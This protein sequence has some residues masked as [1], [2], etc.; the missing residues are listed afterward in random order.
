MVLEHILLPLKGPSSRTLGAFRNVFNNVGPG[1]TISPAL[2]G[3]EA[4]L[5]DDKNDLIALQAPQEEDRL[6]EFFRYFF[7]IFFVVSQLL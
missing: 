2:G 7:P 6:T 3:H 4:R 5:L 1:G